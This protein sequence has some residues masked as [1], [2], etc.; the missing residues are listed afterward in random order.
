MP[1]AKLDHA[2][3]LTAA[4]ESGARKID[5]WDTVTTGFVLEVRSS[6]GKTYCLRYF[7]EGGRQRQLKIGGFHDISFEQARKA[8][9]RLRSEVVLGGDPAAK[10]ETQKAIPTYASLAAQ[11]LAYAKAQLRRPESVERILRCHVLPRWGRLRLSE[12]RSQDVAIWLG[13][14]AAGG[15]KPASVEKIRIIMGRSFALAKEW[16]MPGAESNP[17]RSVPRRSFDNARHRFLSADE[18]ARLLRAC[19]AS[20][21]TQLKSIVGLLLLTG[22]RVSELLHAEWPNIDMERRLW[23]IPLTKNGRGRHVPLSE[24]AM[25]IIKQLPRFDG[26]PY[27]VPNPATLKPFVALKR[28]WQTARSEA[29]LEDV[30][31]HDLRHS[32]ASFLLNAGTDLYTVGKLLGHRSISSSQRYAHLSDET[33]RS[34]VEAGALKLKSNWSPRLQR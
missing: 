2:F 5:F 6:G 3:C 25:N 28:A 14:K 26:C 34:A 1:K 24:P 16:G 31:I 11:H 21:N 13:E 9:K 17:L 33:L 10:K 32:A 15:L 27:V 30:H 4:C 8:A 18:A 19:E 23:L 29:G 20:Q 12:I 22:A 7:D